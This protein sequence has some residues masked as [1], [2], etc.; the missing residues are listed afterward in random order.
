MA[1]IMECDADH[2]SLKGYNG[3]WGIGTFGPPAKL[4]LLQAYHR[5]A[6]YYVCVAI[7]LFTCEA[8]QTLP[9]YTTLLSLL[10]FHY[11]AMRVSL[12]TATTGPSRISDDN[13]EQLYWRTTLAIDL[14]LFQVA[15]LLLY[16]SD[17]IPPFPVPAGKEAPWV[18]VPNGQVLE[19]FVYCKY[20]AQTDEQK[21]RYLRKLTGLMSFC[22]CYW[23]T[24][25]PTEDLKQL[26]LHN[27]TLH[28]FSADST[29]A[30][31]ENETG[32]PVVLF[33]CM[34]HTRADGGPRVVVACSGDNWIPNRILNG[35][36]RDWRKAR[37]TD[38]GA[39][40]QLQTM[41]TTAV[42][43]FNIVRVAILQV[44]PHNADPLF[45]NRLQTR[46]ATN[47]E[48][49]ELVTA[50][51]SN[52]APYGPSPN[53]LPNNFGNNHLTEAGRSFRGCGPTI[54][55]EMSR[56]W[57]CRFL[58]QYFDDHDNE[59]AHAPSMIKEDPTQTSFVANGPLSCAE[60]LCH[61]FCDS[62]ARLITPAQNMP[63]QPYLPFHDA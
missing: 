13:E 53:T 29:V 4:P 16:S 17:T 37:M 21:P 1:T 24:G 30:E 59:H 10:R 26:L 62:A 32:L 63:P 43:R 47:P 46:T 54:Y 2:V 48:Y 61:L 12:S 6:S 14:N 15:L 44:P 57:K 7:D 55:Q 56:C 28:Q 3:T 27:T 31:A 45:A 34:G 22:P 9:E 36:T 50:M 23:L 8:A 18:Q 25:T 38:A 33:V 40:Q 11:F 58:A 49:N 51:Y 20:G 39:R 60:D 19:L 35:W 41:G 52:A 42:A 5:A